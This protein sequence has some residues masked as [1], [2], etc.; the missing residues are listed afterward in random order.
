M[1]RMAVAAMILWGFAGGGAAEGKSSKAVTTKLEASELR[2]FDE[3]PE[4]VKSL[5]NSA[6]GLTGRK[7]GY[8]YG[9]ANPEK[10]G[11]DCSG[12]IY[13]LLREAGFEDVPRTASAQYVWA[14]K[15]D[16][17]EAVVSRS[18]ESFELEDLAP[19]DLLFWTGTYEV[20]RDP[21]VT[22][23]MIYVGEAKSDGTM[24]MVGASDGRSY[25]GKR[26]SGVSVFD[27][28]IPQGKPG[29]GRVGARFVGYAKIPGMEERIDPS[30]GASNVPPESQI[31]DAVEEA[32][33]DAVEQATDVVEDEPPSG[34]EPGASPEES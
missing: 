20:D 28:K 19:G 3:N 10:G 31:E 30:G 2:D 1:G 26:Q 11:M 23:T 27:F 29:T 16:E 34:A 4:A 8:Q 33:A 6:L 14:R 18:K 22:H 13:Y 25:R 15:A 7:L 9:S 32:V 21:P 17:F 12:T 24:L 5:L